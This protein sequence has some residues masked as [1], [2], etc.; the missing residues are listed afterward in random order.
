MKIGLIFL[1]FLII[2][3]FEICSL[4]MEKS[5]ETVTLVSQEGDPFQVP[6]DEALKSANIK[7]ALGSPLPG[8][9]TRSVNFNTISTQTMKELE[10]LMVSA[11]EHRNLQGKRFLDAVESDSSIKYNMELLKAAVFLELNFIKDLFARHFTQQI[12][13]AEN[14][15]VGTAIKFLISS[16][17]PR[18]VSLPLSLAQVKALLTSTFPPE[19]SELLLARILFYHHLYSPSKF[20]RD[21]MQKEFKDID[22]RIDPNYGYSVQDYLDYAPDLIRGITKLR[23]DEA[24]L[25]KEW[26]YTYVESPS[27]SLDYAHAHSEFDY[28]QGPSLEQYIAKE[29][30]NDTTLDLSYLNLKNLFG[31]ENV[32]HI[33]DIEVLNLNN[34]MLSDL[35]VELLIKLKNLKLVLIRSNPISEKKDFLEN[36]RKNLSIEISY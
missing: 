23:K 2:S 18:L 22:P 29:L 28:K 9:R 4:A 3:G 30:S 35:P 13:Q 11:H 25:T 34:N 31:L 1:S 15:S 36:L 17:A 21:Y 16:Y 32:P 33:L 14:P 12:L 5:I 27:P 10:R 26:T 6:L 19:T 8:E 7:I 24:T 20:Y